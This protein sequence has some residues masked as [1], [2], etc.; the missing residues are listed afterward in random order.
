MALGLVMLWL[1]TATYPEFNAT[2]DEP[3]HIAAGV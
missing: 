1:V 3:Y 2:Y